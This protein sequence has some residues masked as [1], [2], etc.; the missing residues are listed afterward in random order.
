M[1]KTIPYG[2]ES[3]QELDIYPAKSSTGPA[4][5]LVFLYGGSWKDGRRGLYGFLGRAFAARGFCVV[6]PDY[7]LHP[8]VRFPA[9]AE[10]AALALAWV[11]DNIGTH[12]GDASEIHLMGHSAGAHTGALLCLDESHLGQVG[13]SPNDIASFTGIAGPYSFNPLESNNVRSVFEHLEDIDHAR[14]IKQAHGNAPPMLLLDSTRDRTVPKHNSEHLTNAIVEADGK[15][16]RITYA[17]PGHT[18][19]ILAIAAPLR[20]M[21]PVFRDA[22][23]FMKKTT[24]AKPAHKKTPEL[25]HPGV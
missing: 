13:M 1:P 8:E 7:R 10:D 15:V 18:G 14:P 17:L 9:F 22:N 5:V 16:T 23:A 19:I 20:W 4:P 11:R 21:A 24:R 12:G 2:A 6:V 25:Q 3:R